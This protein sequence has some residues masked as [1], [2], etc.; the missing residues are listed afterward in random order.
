MD[1]TKGTVVPARIAVVSVVARADTA[2]A[3]SDV[4]RRRRSG[5]AKTRG[6]AAGTS[7]GLWAT[8]TIRL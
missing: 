3:A 7:E 1:R 6:S 8:R 5:A 2:T 4:R